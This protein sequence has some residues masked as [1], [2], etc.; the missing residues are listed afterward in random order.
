MDKPT[1]TEISRSF[2]AGNYDN[3]VGGMKSLQEALQ[4]GDA[5]KHVPEAYTLGFYSSYERK[6]MGIE[7]W[8]YDKAYHSEVG[9]RV[10]ELGYIDS[11]DEKE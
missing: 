7:V 8:L 2:D 1:D 9:K 11:R 10:R 6:E 3:N 4:K 5:M